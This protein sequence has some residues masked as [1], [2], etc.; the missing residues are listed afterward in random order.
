M[1]MVMASQV[2]FSGDYNSGLQLGVNYG[3][4][5]AHFVL[6]GKL[7]RNANVRCDHGQSHLTDSPPRAIG[8][9]AEP[10]INGPVRA[11]SRF[12]QS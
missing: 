1:V 4:V 5:N 9:S 2:T 12:H 7:H 6:P 3:S 10:F 11:R 8:D